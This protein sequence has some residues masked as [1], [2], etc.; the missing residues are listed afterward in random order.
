MRGRT[1]ATQ[2]LVR[3]NKPPVTSVHALERI[4]PKN[5]CVCATPELAERMHISH[6]G[7]WLVPVRSWSAQIDDVVPVYAVLCAAVS[8]AACTEICVLDLR[9]RTTVVEAEHSGRGLHVT[10]VDVASLSD[11]YAVAISCSMVVVQLGEAPRLR[12]D[13]GLSIE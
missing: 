10:R 2:F 4:V 1:R 3:R 12:I 5:A 6:S 11:D 8:S 7:D 9:L 13:L